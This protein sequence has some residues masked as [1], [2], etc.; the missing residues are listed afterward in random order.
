MVDIELYNTCACNPE[1][2][3]LHVLS[4]ADRDIPFLPINLDPR[5]YDITYALHVQNNSIYSL[6]SNPFQHLGNLYLLNVS[7]NTIYTLRDYTFVFL[8]NLTILDVSNNRISEIE[9]HAFAGLVCLEKIYL[10]YNEIVSLDAYFFTDCTNLNMLNVSFNNLKYIN[11]STFDYLTNLTILDLSNNYISEIEVNAFEGL[12][13]LE[14]VYIQHNKL[15]SVS[16]KTFG[17]IPRR[18]I[19]YVDISQNYG[20][21]CVHLCWLNYDIYKSPTKIL[22]L[23]NVLH[24]TVNNT[25]F[26]LS[27]NFNSLCNNWC[28]L[29][30]IHYTESYHPI[31]VINSDMLG[32]LLSVRICINCYEIPGKSRT[33]TAICNKDLGRW[34]YKLKCQMVK[35]KNPSSVIGNAILLGEK[36]HE[37]RCGD[38]IH[39]KCMHGYFLVY[40]NSDTG[41][42]KCVSPSGQEGS[43]V[44]KYQNRWYG[45]PKLFV[46]PRCEKIQE[47]RH[48]NEST[49]ANTTF[50]FP[51][52]TSLPSKHDDY[53][54]NAQLL[55]LIFG[56]AFAAIVV[57]FC[58]TVTFLKIYKIIT[59]R[60]VTT[61][62]VPKVKQGKSVVFRKEKRHITCRQERRSSLPINL[63]TIETTDQ[64]GN[65]QRSLSLS[66]I[67]YQ[68]TAWLR[69]MRNF[70]RQVMAQEN[71]EEYQRV[72]EHLYETI[73]F[74]NDDVNGYEKPIPR[75]I[76]SHLR[77]KSHAESLGSEN[78]RVQDVQDNNHEEKP[79]VAES[80]SPLAVVGSECNNRY[81]NP[82]QLVSPELDP[83]YTP[84]HL[85]SHT[86]V[87]AGYMSMTDTRTG[88]KNLPPEG[89]ESRELKLF[90]DKSDWNPPIK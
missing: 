85:V 13:F 49:Q 45:S 61:P 19:I 66:G 21:K 11:D 35:C 71:T 18:H 72:R 70:S 4:Y 25:L 43:L 44:G 82:V 62:I 76:D 40:E 34:V 54:L 16:S 20:L 12:H 81:M 78:A 89:T 74:D 51:F 10:Q 58:L 36:E 8:T 67:E 22:K 41:M 17:R 69:E 5:V 33:F 77:I 2:S 83:A 47:F 90:V 75:P 73:P 29:D 26:T 57:C 9:L 27:E 65:E 38:W 87:H 28:N 24:C 53:N 39:Y 32:Q 7:F 88:D 37:I 56:V 48:D 42:A 79:K 6:D 55:G 15:K 80:L 14:W 60:T 46:T 23:L 59:K 86:P 68:E 31:P 30:N 84:M 1:P 64:I 3:D 50:T 52:S 63:S